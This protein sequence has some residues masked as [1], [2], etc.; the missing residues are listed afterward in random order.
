MRNDIFITGSIIADPLIE[1]AAL[2]R[3]LEEEAGNPALLRG[4]QTSLAPVL[5]KSFLCALPGRCR[6]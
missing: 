3:E 1:L 2:K 5:I 4:R 6:Q